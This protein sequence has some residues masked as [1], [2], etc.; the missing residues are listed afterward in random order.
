[1]IDLTPLWQAE[2]AHWHWR[3][4][5]AMCLAAAAFFVFSAGTRAT[6]P[7]DSATDAGARP[8][9]VWHRPECI[10]RSNDG[11]FFVAGTMQREGRYPY[12]VW[13]LSGDGQI[14]W[15]R[16]FEAENQDA[17]AAV[18][19]T[20]DG[21][22]LVTGTMFVYAPPDIG[23]R[24]WVKKLSGDGTT[25]YTKT[26]PGY[27]SAQTI[28]ATATNRY[29]L[30]GMR[31]NR[32][33]GTGGYDGWVVE[34]DDD[35]S[36]LWERTFEGGADEGICAVMPTSDGGIICVAASGHYNKFGQGPSEVWVFK[37]DSTGRLLAE[38]RIPGARL[39][40]AAQS[41]AGDGEQFAVVYSKTELPPICEAGVT[42]D[43]S[44]AA[45]VSAFDGQ[46]RSVW[47]RDVGPYCSLYT[48]L[49]LTNEDRGYTVIGVTTEGLRIDKLTREGQVA[50]ASTIENTA[51]QLDNVIAVARYTDG[52][53]GVGDVMD[54]QTDR[55]GLVLFRVEETGPKLLWSKEY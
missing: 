22:V 47:R 35:A 42:G 24:T 14:V 5:A 17:P 7:A 49:L 36:V 20:P 46:L 6:P 48:P 29:I 8:S 50:A 32:V 55:E 11:G 12:W 44:F 51:L 37:C 43:L 39:M 23:Y 3:N 41:I 13:R 45:G 34:I 4:L 31:P 25:V 54:F 2:D 9:V 10:C 52:F 53:A 1:M 30:A 38:A 21:G 28:V 16:E 18:I 19:P 40:K 33:I 26:L 27:R 15:Q